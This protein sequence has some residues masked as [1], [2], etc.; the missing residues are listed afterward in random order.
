ME[1]EKQSQLESFATGGAGGRGVGPLRRRG[2]AHVLRVMFKANPFKIEL[3]AGTVRSICDSCLP[4]T[5]G[6]ELLTDFLLYAYDIKGG[7]R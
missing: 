3:E 5:R 6:F 1:L 2:G 4:E 7:L